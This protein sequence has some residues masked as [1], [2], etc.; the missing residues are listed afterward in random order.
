MKDMV[1]KWLE[2]IIWIVAGFYAL[3]GIIV[4]LFMLVQGEPVGLAMIVGGPIMAVL[5]AGGIFIGIGIHDNTRRTV[6]AVEKLA[7]R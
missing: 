5:I 4:G 7:A 1:I 3:A 2:A 6:A